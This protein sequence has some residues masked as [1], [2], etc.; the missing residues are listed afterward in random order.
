MTR[1]E[2]WQL[3]TEFTQSESLIKHALAVEAAMRHYA[4]VL[5]GDPDLWGVVGL[6][7]DFDYERWPDPPAHTR[8]GAR[9]LRERGVDEEIV[10]AVLSHADWNQEQWP[11]DRPLRKALYAVDE[12]C[13]FVMAVAYVRPERL[14]GMTAKSVRKKLKQKAFAAAVN[15]EDI[16]R[17]AELLGLP[18]DEHIDH[19]ITALQGIK[20][21]LGFGNPSGPA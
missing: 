8:E 11:R 10:G 15:R 12:L 7:H 13:G 20:E 4:G 5:G 2:A 18:L 17:G 3:L 19:V 14:D 9:I 1:E 6:I 16:Q 21:Q